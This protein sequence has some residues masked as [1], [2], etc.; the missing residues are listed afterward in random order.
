MSQKNKPAVTLGEIV[1]QELDP[2]TWKDF[3]LLFKRHGGVW[4]GCWCMYYHVARGWSKR[5]PEQNKTDKKALMLNG[6]AHGLILYN[7]EDPIGW[8][9]YGPPEELPRIDRKRSYHPPKHDYWRLTCF[10][11][12]RRYRNKGIAKLLLHAAL[13]FMKKHKVKMVEAY[14]IDTQSRKYRS[15]FLWPGTLQLFESAGFRTV[16]TLGKNTMIVRKRL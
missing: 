11:I 2:T 1:V 13:R 16:R 12:D 6:K 5:T 8:C 15:D 14:P 9:Q 4:G 7:D 10:F 3:E